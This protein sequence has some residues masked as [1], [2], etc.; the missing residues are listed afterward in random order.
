MHD[1]NVVLIGRGLIGQALY[2]RVEEQ[3]GWNVIRVIERGAY[4]GVSGSGRF[5]EKMSVASKLI[6][7]ETDLVFLAIPTFDDGTTALRYIEYC[8]EHS[9]PVVTCEKGSLSY[10]FSKLEPYLDRIGYSATVGGGTRLL[11]YLNERLKGRRDVV[12][13]A[14]INGTLNY[15]F[16]EISRAGRSFGEAV[17]EAKR[18]GYAEP[19]ASSPLE[20]VRGEIKDTTMKATVLFNICLKQ[21][22]ALHPGKMTVRSF[23][24]KDLSKLISEGLNRRYIVTF[25]PESSG[26]NDDVIGG[27]SAKVDG[28][29]V[30]AG[31][32]RIDS[33]PLFRDWLP[34]GVN[35]S[36]LT[37]EGPYGEDGIYTLT[38]PGAGPKP[39]T[40]SM[41][42]DALR[43]LDSSRQAD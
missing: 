30:N 14:V 25:T 33:N 40:S 15:I 26:K 34:K 11:P 23:E 31:F 19:G 38:G 5:N 10:N 17:E 1:T 36:I 9:I 32:Q 16:D 18:L 4:S 12:I 35:N 22:I 43:L 37:Y 7:K 39:T 6:P 3:Y 21:S 8:V 20:L 29:R 24:S 42:R 13:H 41:M 2:E 28:W 27:Y